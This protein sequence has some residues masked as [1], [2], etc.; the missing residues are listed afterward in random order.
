VD[1]DYAA[2]LILRYGVVVSI[3]LILT[4]LVLLHARNECAGLFSAKS[5]LNTSVIAP[6]YVITGVPRLDPLAI[7]LLGL[8]VLITTPIL[9]VILG[10]LSF[11]RERNWIYVAITVIVLFNLTLAILILPS[12]MNLHANPGA[13]TEA[14]R[15]SPPQWT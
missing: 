8:M 5:K 2:S 4:G 1:L 13:F 15:N 3:A 11:A 10:M 14:C 7:L 9:R 12:T 6:T